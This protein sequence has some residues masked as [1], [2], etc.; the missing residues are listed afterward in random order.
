VVNFK[1]FAGPEEP[2]SATAQDFA[3][4]QL[5]LRL[6]E[7]EAGEAEEIS[8]AAT[9][10]RPLPLRRGTAEAEGLM[11][12]RRRDSSLGGTTRSPPASPSLPVIL[13]NSCRFCDIR[14]NNAPGWLKLLG[15]ADADSTSM[16][17]RVHSSLEQF[18]DKARKSGSHLTLRWREVDSNFRFRCV[19]RS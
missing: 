6:E 2:R 7:L 18:F 1:P 14:R 4:E 19:R 12:V 13:S 16:S 5:E 10:H 3:A 8:K 17:R 15:I 9:E 11:M